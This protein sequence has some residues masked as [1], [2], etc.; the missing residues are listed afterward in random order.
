MLIRQQLLTGATGALGAHILHE[1]LGNIDVRRI[2]CLV[3]AGDEEEGHNRVSKSLVDRGRKPLSIDQNVFCYPYDIR[4]PGLGLEPEAQ[5]NIY[6][7]V[8]HIIHVSSS[9]APKEC[10]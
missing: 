9:D 5:E 10:P 6:M 7:D 2:F 8:T 1:L 4:E 3:R